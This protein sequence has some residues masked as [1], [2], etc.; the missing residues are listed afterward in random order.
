MTR[1]PLL[2]SLLSTAPAAALVTFSALASAQAPP[3]SE[4]YTIGG[5]TFRP[6]LEVR[7][8]GE[9]RRHP[10][11]TGGAVYDSTAVLS[12]G[13]STTLPTV[14]DTQKG[15]GTQSLLSERSRLGLAVDRGPVT[16]AL[17]LQDARVWGNT[18]TAFVG[19]GQPR[20]PVFAPLDAYVDVHTAS[21]SVWFRLGR[22]RVTWGDGRLI[23][24]NDWSPTARSF[25]AARLGFKFWIIDLEF[26]A[27]LLAA[28]GGLPP[29]VSGTKEAATEG[30]GAQLYGADMTWRILPLLN[31]E[32]TGLARIVRQPHPDWLTPSDT[33]TV[34]GRIFGDRRGFRYAAEG[35]YQFGKVASY[36][37]DRAI[38][39]FAV[40]ARASW[41]TALPGRLTFGADGQ[42][43]SGDKGD[44]AGKQRRFDPLFP[45]EH[46]T[47]DPM[48]MFAWSNVLAAGGTFGAMPVD[49]QNLFING[50]RVE[51]S[52]QLGYHFVNLAEP[53]GRWTTASLIP[54]GASSA[55]TS[56]SLGH[57][58][59]A[60]FRFSPWRAIDFE[61][62]YGFFYFGDGAR[63][64]L[65]ETG[66]PA[67][68][69][70]WAYFQTVVRLP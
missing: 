51:F 67:R 45:D 11:D 62:G 58:A 23:G 38:E 64:I 53:N 17:I 43:A 1:P 6:S 2:R 18:D 37:A 66:R 46:Q 14:V 7:L 24:E 54:V 69:Q 20:L 27:A 32:A 34:G 39:A 55:N 36:G 49:K 48:N 60:R 65:R 19:P 70:H 3:L 44:F 10:I 16:A 35:Y 59:D 42:Y 26:M 40:A 50:D 5:W 21:R 28:P 12:E 29:T 4:S 47:I 25:D 52:L 13:F 33:Y 68:W 15:V 22:Q 63:Q 31:I 9:Y 8:R 57:E 61:T 30:T 56:R 41:E